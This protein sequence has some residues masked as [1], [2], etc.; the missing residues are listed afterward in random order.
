MSNCGVMNYACDRSALGMRVAVM[1]FH[2]RQELWLFNPELAD[3]PEI[4]AF[5]K[6]DLPDARDAWPRLSVTLGDN[7]TPVFAI[8]AV[9]GEDDVALL[10]MTCGSCDA[11]DATYFKPDVLVPPCGDS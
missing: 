5:N 11:V 1:I 10:R 4:V 8:S 3:K 2:E 7:G 6:M 9:T